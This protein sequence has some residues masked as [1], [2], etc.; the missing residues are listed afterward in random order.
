MKDKVQNIAAEIESKKEDLNSNDL[1][2]T[3]VNEELKQLI[4]KCEELYTDYDKQRNQVLELKYNKKNDAVSATSAW[5]TNTSATSAWGATSSIDQYASAYDTTSTAA[6]AA[7]TTNTSSA[8]I[9][10]TGPAPE[11]FVKYRAVYEF[12]ARNADEISFVP[13]DIILV[14]LEQNAEPGW[15]AGEINGHTGWF[16]ETYVEKIE[17]DYA[18]SEPAAA[19]ISAV[20]TYAAQDSYNDNSQTAAYAYVFILLYEFGLLF[21]FFLHFSGQQQCHQLLQMEMLSII[22]LPI[23]MNRLRLAI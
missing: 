2:M 17:N 12:T 16:P 6:V 5:D 18:A 13:G 19:A 3:E 4:N 7:D 21:N 1:Q 8:A 20:D 15:F 9:D 14:P 22:L 10:N 23:P 11:G